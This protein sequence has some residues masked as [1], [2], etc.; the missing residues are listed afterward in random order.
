MDRLLRPNYVTTQFGK[1]LKKHGLRFPTT[2]KWRVDETDSGVAQAHNVPNDGGCVCSSGLQ[3]QGTV[4]GNYSRIAVKLS[5]IKSLYTNKKHFNKI[6]FARSLNRI[7]FRIKLLDEKFYAKRKGA[8]NN[9]F[10][11]PLFEIGN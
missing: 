3:Q 5:G 2:G 8:V 10:T 11:T 7:N 4:I 9:M 6:R 1:L